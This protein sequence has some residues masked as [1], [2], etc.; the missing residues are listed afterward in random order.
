MYEDPDVK[1]SFGESPA[2]STFKAAP[3]Q[4]CTRDQPKADGATK[5]S[6]TAFR[7]MEKRFKYYK[8]DKRRGG[9]HAAHYNGDGAAGNRVRDPLSV[10]ADM[11]REFPDVLDMRRRGDD[12]TTSSSSSSVVQLVGRSPRSG[13]D[14]FAVTTVPGL[15]LIP[16]A[17]DVDRQ[18]RILTEALGTYPRPPHP[19]NL[20]NLGHDPLTGYV[21]GLRW[22]TVGYKYNW[23]TKTYDGT[24]SPMPVDVSELSAEL[25]RDLAEVVPSAAPRA[26]SYS[27]QTA[28]VNYFPHDTAMMAHQDVSESCLD[29]PLISVSLGCSAI[30]LMGTEDRNVA[31]TPILLRSGD[32]VFMT[33]ATRVGFHAVP[34]ILQDCPNELCG[35]PGLEQMSMLRVN[36]NV[37]QVH[38]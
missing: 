33:G 19:N 31:P 23:T 7:Q 29:R 13:R 22:V 35:E 20:T 28:I 24:S 18:K 12:A 27:P 30:F 9:K 3:P 38:D 15:F 21:P 17:L 1:A 4:Q 11:L 26:A 16:K 2:T 34:R 5:L 37:R 8:P 36:I 32:V 6:E 10:A 25:H 14:V